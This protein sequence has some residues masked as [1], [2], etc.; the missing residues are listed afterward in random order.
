MKKSIL[1]FMMMLF[2]ITSFSQV[3]KHNTR[4]KI[5]TV[6]ELLA[7]D[8][9]SKLM[10]L[11]PSTNELKY[12]TAGD[13]SAAVVSNIYN[14]DGTIPS[15]T[16][17]TITIAADGSLEISAP[18][19]SSFFIGGGIGG[20]SLN[21]DFNDGFAI[22]SGSNGIN[23]GNASSLEII[24]S[25]G[26]QIRPGV[27]GLVTTPTPG[28][29]LRVND[30]NGFVSWENA[31]VSSAS[32]GL[33]LA[34]SDIKLGGSLT[35]NTAIDSGFFDFELGSY[36]AGEEGPEFANGL[37]VNNTGNYVSV[38]KNGFQSGLRL[39]DNLIKLSYQNNDKIEITPNNVL[40][41]PGITNVGG[42]NNVDFVTDQIRF[43]KSNGAITWA[44][45]DVQ[46]SGITP[47]G[48]DATYFLPQTEGRLALDNDI[49]VRT[50]LNGLNLNGTQVRLGLNDLIENT[51][52]RHAG[53]DYHIGAWFD[54]EGSVQYGNGFT[55][56]A[57]Q[58]S[59]EWKNNDDSFLKMVNGGLTMGR[60]IN[61][62]GATAAFT[63]AQNDT[64][65]T[66]SVSGKT[67]FSTNYQQS[68]SGYRFKS[69]VNAAE[70]EL[71]F[72]GI[73]ADRNVQF[74]NKDIT[75]ADDADLKNATG[76]ADYVDTTYTD[77]S[78]FSVVANTDTKLP[79]NAGTVVD[80]QKPTDVTTFY[81][82]VSETITGRNGDGVTIT[83]DFKAEP[84]APGTEYLE[85]WFDITG[86]T[87]TPSNLANLYRRI[88]TFPKG[89][90]VER[91][92]N[93][94]VTGYT[95]ATWEANGAEV[96]VRANG[97]VDLYDIRYVITRTHKAR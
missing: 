58:I 75:V 55:M 93:F 25:N 95:L 56:L 3:Y 77:I 24:G 50:A 73:N 40:I 90:G 74:P 84:T 61:G 8:S 53:F 16:E 41:S 36:I 28:Q 62:G 94:T 35:E 22:T 30:I 67:L 86:G 23:T 12:I 81:D 52:F 31:P 97:T 76:W 46:G 14:S 13:L 43:R 64:D 2:S 26:L 18:D 57:D 68:D 20:Y 49:T 85:I 44:V 72:R 88:V 65:L 47:T 91:N 38:T 27:G 66:F 33:N 42:P 7:L 10:V 78:P 34:G 6:N 17:R 15:S 19:G 60:H 59:Y 39:E 5:S 54:E 11:D 29:F 63:G 70:I 48:S 21:A 1:L 71:D 45:L 96:Y 89:N 37:Q 32:N 4:V 82:S 80:S 83:I 92:I 51:Y 69:N 87:G 9:N 79:N